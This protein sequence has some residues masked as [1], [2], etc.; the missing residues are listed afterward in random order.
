GQART[1]GHAAAGS[2]PDPGERGRV[3]RSG[4]GPLQ[5]GDP[6]RGGTARRGGVGAGRG[7]EF[8]KSA[9][10]ST[11][12]GARRNGWSGVRAR[13][14]RAGPR[15]PR[16]IPAEVRRR[17]LQRDGF[18]C[19]FTGGDGHVCGSTHRLELD[20]RKPIAEGGES[21]VENVQIVCRAHNQYRAELKFGKPR[22]A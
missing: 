3:A 21:T 6:A 19:R 5:A 9:T 1:L 10:E 12:P 18:S 20:H 8:A 16:Y 14:A 2:A 22:I 4:G 7:G 11:W 13:W 15:D 17:V